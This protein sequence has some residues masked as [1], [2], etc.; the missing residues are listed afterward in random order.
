MAGASLPTRGAAGKSALSDLLAKTEPPCSRVG[1]G[2][3]AEGE[4]EVGNRV[5]GIWREPWRDQGRHKGCAM[6]PARRLQPRARRRGRMSV[7]V[8]LLV[9]LD[10]LSEI[11]DFPN[12]EV[13]SILDHVHQRLARF[14]PLIKGHIPAAVN[15]QSPEDGRDLVLLQAE[16]S[17]QHLEN[18]RICKARQELLEVHLA[19]VVGISAP[20]D[21]LQES[22]L[23]TLLKVIVSVLERHSKGQTNRIVPPGPR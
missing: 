16:A 5:S 17:I 9:F 23:L 1:A 20:E 2:P 12:I 10:Q 8:V 7:R 3:G 19:T 15:I 11:V 21:I 14:Q 22:Q 6:M 4:A 13:H 18:L